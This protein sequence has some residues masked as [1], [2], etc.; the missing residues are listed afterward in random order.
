LFYLGELASGHAHLAQ[1]AALY[2]PQQHRSLAFSTFQNPGVSCRCFAARILWYLGFP[3]Q[4]LAWSQAGLLLAQDRAHP[5][6]LAFAL[7]V[8]ALVQQLRREGHGV[9]ERAEAAITLARE[10][11]F[12]FYEAL[13]TIQRGWSLVVQGQPVEGIEQMRQGLAVY[14]ATGSA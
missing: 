6:S 12:P 1:G 10:Q 11:G 5:F 2:D 4:A 7:N 3:D 13:G 9:H 8:A 14:R